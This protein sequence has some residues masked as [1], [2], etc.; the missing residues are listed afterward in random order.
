MLQ[1]IEIG[2]GGS[3]SV[4]FC[5][6]TYNALCTVVSEEVRG[7]DHNLTHFRQPSLDGSGL[8][9]ATVFLIRAP[10]S[11]QPADLACCFRGPHVLTAY[12][13]H[14]TATVRRGLRNALPES[15]S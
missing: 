5:R 6:E 1:V 8:E 10:G 11:Q 4:L 14:G 13:V 2:V 3:E 15:P 7:A 12:F 9:M